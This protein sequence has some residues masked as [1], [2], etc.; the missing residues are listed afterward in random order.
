[1]TSRTRWI[2]V[3]LVA[4]LAV[5]MAG[6]LAIWVTGSSG[7]RTAPSSPG[8][9]GETPGGSAAPTA[10]GAPS[11]S[12]PVLTDAEAA[13]RDFLDRYVDP[14]GRVVRRDQGGDTV[15]EGQAYALLIAVAVGDRERFDAVWSWTRD[16][17]ARESDGLLSWRWSEG[18]VVDAESASDAD[19]DA[20]RALVLAAETFDEPAYRT[21]GITLGQAIL[22][23][24]TVTT[25]DGRILVAGT[26][27]RQAP[28][29]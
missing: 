4:V 12:A 29:A 8:A 20:A 19:L 15:S 3:V 24:E 28:Y 7:P 10:P 23:H 26:W 21:A 27:A 16:T 9:S 5:G 22:D 11:T 6:G 17:L 2:I 18:A 25:T 13:G 1:M 14:D